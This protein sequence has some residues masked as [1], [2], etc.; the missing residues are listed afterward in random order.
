[1]PNVD[2]HGLEVLKKAAIDI[3][4]TPKR[5]YA[6]QTVLANKFALPA[7]ADAYTREVIGNSVVY[8]FRQGGIAGTILKTIT[9]FYQSPQDPDNTGGELS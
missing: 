1:M 4:S 2:D 7:N 8:K 9:L 6:L 5:D 3:G